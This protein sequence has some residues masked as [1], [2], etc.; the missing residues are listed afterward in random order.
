M[1]ISPPLEKSTDIPEYP[2]WRITVGQ[3]HRMIETGILTEDDPVELL[4]GLLIEKMTKNRRHSV[5]TRR[6][7]RS[8]ERIMPSGWYVDSQEPITTSDS[9]PEPDVI[10]VRES[11]SEVTDRQPLAE[12]VTLVIEVS[13]ATL[14]KDRTV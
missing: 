8:L 2:V 13:D 5:S 9:E 4:E 3:Y 1:A 7:R 6:T 14:P 11:M 12:E 10:V